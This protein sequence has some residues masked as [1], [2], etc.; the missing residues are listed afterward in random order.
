LAETGS[1]R[2]SHAYC[3]NCVEEFDVK[4]PIIG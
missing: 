3:T 1:E 4:Q 2:S